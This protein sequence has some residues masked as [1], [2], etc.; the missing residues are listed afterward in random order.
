[1]PSPEDTRVYRML[2]VVDNVLNQLL[3][4][5]FTVVYRFWHENS[6][7]LLISGTPDGYNRNDEIISCLKKS[8]HMSGLFFGF[9]TG[10]ARGIK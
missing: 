5:I 10:R 4:K 6:K 1:M 9:S 8:F 2:C 7:I 3:Y